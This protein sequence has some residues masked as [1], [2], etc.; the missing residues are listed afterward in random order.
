MALKKINQS[1]YFTKILKES[2]KISRSMKQFR[3]KKK[4]GVCTVPIR[5]G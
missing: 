4:L 2:D 3:R 5:K 1:Y